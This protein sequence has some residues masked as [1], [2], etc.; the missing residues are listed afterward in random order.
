MGNELSVQGKD[1]YNKVVIQ[2]QVVPAKDS[3]AVTV[4]LRF[5]DSKKTANVNEFRFYEHDALGYVNKFD[6]KGRVISAKYKDEYNNQ[7]LS[8]KYNEKGQLI[9]KVIDNEIFPSFSG[10]T[11]YQYNKNGTLAKSAGVWADGEAVVINRDTLG[12]K[13][14]EIYTMKDGTE[15][16]TKFD[17]EGYPI[18]KTENSKN[19]ERL[20]EYTKN[21]DESSK[22]VFHEENKEFSKVVIRDGLGKSREYFVDKN[23]KE[24]SVVKKK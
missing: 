13:M 11:T 24:I 9:K 19:G 21:S 7:N 22:Q 15:R 23:G 1:L 5:S 14:S 20:Y 2:K 3:P 12:V 16:F 8:Y 10:A 4:P 17:K 6:K 18:Y